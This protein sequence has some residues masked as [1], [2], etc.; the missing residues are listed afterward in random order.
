MAEGAA[1]ARA[2]ALLHL[3]SH[4]APLQTLP[5]APPGLLQL[6]LPSAHRVP[7][8]LRSQPGFQTRAVWRQASE[9]GQ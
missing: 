1:G 6:T 4:P 3:P 7:Q 2:A 5:G 9:G 8:E